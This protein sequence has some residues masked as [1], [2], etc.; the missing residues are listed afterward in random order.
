MDELRDRLEAVCARAFPSKTNPRVVDL[1]HLSDGWETEVHAFG[2]DADNAPRENLILRMYPGRDAREKSAGEFF[3]L[4]QLFKAGY[5]VPRTMLLERDSAVLGKPFIL[6][7]LIDGRPLGVVMAGSD[8]GREQKLLQL[9]CELF[10]QLHRIDWW[11]YVPDAA[12]AEREGRLDVLLHA[13]QHVLHNAEMYDFDPLIE[14]LDQRLPKIQP[15]RAAI[16]H[17]DFHPYNVLLR[18]DGRAFVIDWGAAMIGD[19]RL[20]LAW[21]LLLAY[22]HGSPGMRDRILDEYTRMTDYP[23]EPIAY[24]E[25]AACLRR[26]FDVSMSVRFG[27]AERG[28]RP[29]AVALMKQNAGPIAKVYELLFDRTGIAIPLIEHMLAEW[30]TSGSNP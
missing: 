10:V 13:V 18:D 27:A 23:V 17:R 22:A 4:Q 24:F 30:S 25:V 28:M 14:W 1:R 20:D 9:F 26:L 15:V 12:R 3:T 16:C 5:P 11:P 8:Q 7:E 6:M 29:E 19:P 21:T 2:L